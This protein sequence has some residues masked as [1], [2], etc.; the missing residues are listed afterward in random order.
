MHRLC[1]EMQ[2]KMSK[3]T[4][5]VTSTKSVDE[6]CLDSPLMIRGTP[7][8][9]ENDVWQRGTKDENGFLHLGLIISDSSLP[10]QTEV[11]TQPL[12]DYG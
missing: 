6:D 1:R 12:A 10:W 8:C 2:L 4:G 7:G 11:A 3:L 9:S 5:L